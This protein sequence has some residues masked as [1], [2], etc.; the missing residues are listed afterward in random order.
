[1]MFAVAT[2]SFYK[3]QNEAVFSASKS[4]NIKRNISDFNPD[5]NTKNSIHFFSDNKEIALNLSDKSM[6][7]LKN[8]F[9]ENDFLKLS[10]G[11]IGLSGSAAAFVEGWYKDIMVNRDFL[12]ADMDKNGKIEKNEYLAL[13]NSVQDVA[14]NQD[15]SQSDGW[16]VL[17][18][19]KS[20]TGYVGSK[21]SDKSLSIEELMDET[22]KSDRNFDGSIS[23]LEYSAKGGT[24]MQGY[25]NWAVDALNDILDDDE[26]KEKTTLILDPY[27]QITPKWDGISMKEI[28]NFYEGKGEIF[29]HFQLNGTII[30]G[31]KASK[32]QKEQLLD[33]FPEFRALIQNNPNITKE[34]LLR[35]K[36]Q[37]RITQ[38]YQVHQKQ[39]LQKEF[40]Q[41]FF[42]T[43]LKA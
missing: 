35:L 33:E 32:S 31:S 39:D 13:K 7:L 3:T 4:E 18:M 19:A 15:L 11:N 23:R 16:V 24:D 30:Q 22:L 27:G 38:N 40:T 2:S 20:T 21:I 36:N 6:E 8:H 1:M 10:N 29:N 9:S 17:R 25:T 14:E 5:K 37:Q 41:K 42:Q 12:N 43:D 34:E 26:K 28:S